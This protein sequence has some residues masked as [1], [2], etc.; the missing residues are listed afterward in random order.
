MVALGFADPAVLQMHSREAGPLPRFQLLLE[1]AL[2]ILDVCPHISLACSSCVPPAL[3]QTVQLCCLSA[4]LDTWY[5]IPLFSVGMLWLPYL[6]SLWEPAS[7]IFN[8]KLI[9]GTEDLV[10]HLQPTSTCFPL[11]TV[12]A[13]ASPLRERGHCWRFSPTCLVGGK[14]KVSL[15]C[16]ADGFFCVKRLYFIPVV[17]Q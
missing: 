12:L 8:R 3:Q 1:G 9:L 11:Q 17:Q 6:N 2:L 7:C 16:G 15:Q 5:M 4:E 13:P 14:R 10:L